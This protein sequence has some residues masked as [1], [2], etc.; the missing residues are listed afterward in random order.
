MNYNTPNLAPKQ[1]Y[2]RTDGW[3]GYLIPA[4]AI[5]GASDTGMAW[6][7]PAPTDRVDKEI[8]RFRHEVLRP[9]GIKSR[10]R[11]TQSS[12]AFMVKR[13][14]VVAREDF[15]RAAQLTMQSSINDGSYHYLHDADL[16]ELGYA[17]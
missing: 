12:N 11:T 1:R 8:A 15:Q 4:R 13:W 14:L 16:T 3:R 7:S 2:H 9:A 6:D 10:V 17:S 5:A